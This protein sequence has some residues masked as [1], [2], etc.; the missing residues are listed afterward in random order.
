MGVAERC[1]D[2]VAFRCLSLLENLLE[3]LHPR[4]FAIR[5]WD[6]SGLAPEPGQP[7][8]FT[9]VI[10]KPSALRTMALAPD[11]LALGEAY[12]C[13]DLDIEGDLGC[14]FAL[15]DH[16]VRR[17]GSVGERFRRA[18]Q[19]LSL[20]RED[21]FH[22]LRRRAKIGGR[23]HSI[24]R[25]R[26]AVGY[27][28]DVSNEFYALWLD[29]RMVY[30]CGYFADP[31]EELDVAQERKLDTI[32]RKLRLLPG[33]R[34][35][36]IGSGWGG[37]ILHAAARYGAEAVGITLNRPQADLAGD[38]IREAGQGARCRVEVRDYR[39]TDGFGVFDKLASVGMFE[40][41]GIS[42]LKEYFRRAFRLLRP[43]GVFLN[44]G[45]ACH[46]SYPVLP[47]PSFSDHHIFPDGELVPVSTTLRIAEEEGFEVRDVESLREHYVLTLRHW[48]RRLEERAGEARRLVGEATYRTWRLY[49]AGAAHTFLV[50]KNNVYQT[51][52]VKPE[53]GRAGLPLTREDWYRREPQ[54][55]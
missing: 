43:G 33:D 11:E 23:L 44:Q 32:C 8:R 35:L 1:S 38:R 47:G 26:A 9:L 39:E 42:R 22:R 52:L 10:R 50:G 54:A 53:K 45:I 51:L 7:A 12:V 48:R 41:V 25:D 29:R 20:P 21:R 5:L 15:G 18:R 36:D 40:H 14:A 17:R 55:C 46:P 27:H 13:G 24:S 31:G 6:G 49:L 19:L 2:E 34:L 28:Y 3:S 37:L 4:D 16:L 30:S